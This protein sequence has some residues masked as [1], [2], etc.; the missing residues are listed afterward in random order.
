MQRPNI[1]LDSLLE[2]V[3]K[4]I[5]GPEEM[6]TIEVEESTGATVDPKTSVTSVSGQELEETDVPNQTTEKEEKPAWVYLRMCTKMVLYSTTFHATTKNLS[7]AN[8][9]QQL[10]D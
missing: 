4:P 9:K 1:S 10:Q 6:L 7:F 2:I 3:H 8:N 5:S